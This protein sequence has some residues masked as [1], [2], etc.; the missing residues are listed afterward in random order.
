[1]SYRSDH[2]GALAEVTAAGAAVTFTT[3]RPGSYNPATDVWTAGTAG[4]VTGYAMQVDGDPR[5]Y[6]RLGLVQSE[7]PTLLFTAETY[8]EQPGLGDRV[9]W[10]GG[11]FT[12]RSVRPLAP[13]GTAIL[14]Y[15]VVAR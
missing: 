8:G 9:A 5:E 14:S 13:D 3:D 15:V 7:A 1:M 12:V 10:G 6:E 2:R 11:A 4:S